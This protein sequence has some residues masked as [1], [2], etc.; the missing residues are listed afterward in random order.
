MG[1]SKNKQAHLVVEVGHVGGGE[2][3]GRVGLNEGP[4]AKHVGWVL[5]PHHA[6]YVQTHIALQEKAN[7]I[8]RT[9]K[10]KMEENTKGRGGGGERTGP[11]KFREMVVMITYTQRQVSKK[12]KIESTHSAK[13]PPP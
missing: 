8:R 13:L 5:V 3:G 12:N 6:S 11:E 2:K 7:R 4:A 10:A 9:Q 1:S